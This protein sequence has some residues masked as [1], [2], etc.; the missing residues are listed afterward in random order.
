MLGSFDGR[1]LSLS[2]ISRFPS[3]SVQIL[4]SL[5]W[6]APAIF[7][8]IKDAIRAACRDGALSGIGVTTW[9]VDY[10]LLGRSG[11]L[12]GN[13][14]HYRDRRTDGAPEQVFQKVD[15]E[16]LFRATGVQFMQVNTIFQLYAAVRDTP[17]VI[18]AA[19]RLLFMPDLMNYWLT[20]E[21]AAEYTIASTSMMYDSNATGQTRAPRGNWAYGILEKLGLPTRILPEVVAPGFRLGTLHP[22]LREELGVPDVPVFAVCCHDTASAVMGV[23]ATEGNWAFLSSG[24]WSILGKEVPDPI[25]TEQTFVSNCSNEGGYGGTIRFLKNIMG[26]WILQECRRHWMEQGKT[27]SYEE[28]SARAASAEPFAACI[29]ASIDCKEFLF[30]GRMPDRIVEFCRKTGQR[31]PSSEAQMTRVIL[32][33]L[34]LECRAT[35]DIL[36]KIIG[37]RVDVLHIVGGGSQNAV[38]AQFTASATRTTVVA[39]PPEATTVGNLLVQAMASG[40]ISDTAQLREVVRTSFPLVVYQPRDT[41]AWEA[42][43]EKYRRIRLTGN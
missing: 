1:K 13:P 11:A 2:Q 14:Y 26:L 3:A 23:P 6:D 38:L 4:G 28:L 41:D 21:K 10:G 31:C 39:G 9:G 35:L 43:Y 15:R 33:S 25:M 27:Y 24:T 5:H 34:A 30:P 42:Q 40:E 20:G 18:G 16:Q 7:A 37:G 12:L 22:S 19:D 32:E 29:D 8:E 17:E 36:E